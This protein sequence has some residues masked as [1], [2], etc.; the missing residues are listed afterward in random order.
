MRKNRGWRKEEWRERGRRKKVSE[1]VV[2]SFFI[3]LEWNGWESSNIIHEDDDTLVIISSLKPLFPFLTFLLSFFLLSPYFLHSS[4]FLLP[5]LFFILVSTKKLYSFIPNKGWNREGERETRPFEK[6]LNP[7]ENLEEGNTSI[8]KSC[9]IYTIPSIFLSFF[10]LGTKNIWW[11]NKFH[12]MT[13][14]IHYLMIV[15]HKLI[16]DLVCTF[17]WADHDTLIIFESSW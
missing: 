8:M 2:F 4:Y 10:H 5:F 17:W 7:E 3:S 11:N 14:G 16:L 13:L 12:C 9:I 6:I 15:S 1:D